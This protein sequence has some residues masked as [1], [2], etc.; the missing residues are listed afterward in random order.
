MLFF[1]TLMVGTFISISAYSWFSMWVGLE[2][3]LLSF[4]PLIW[5]KNNALSSESAIKYFI[6]QS[7][8]SIF[9][10]FSVILN[11]TMSEFFYNISHFFYIIMDSALL[12]KM[13]AAP[14]HFWMP[15]ICEGLTWWNNLILLT[16]QKIA[17]FLLIFFNP[18][19]EMYIIIIIISSMLT[20]GI[21]GWNQVSLR[22]IMVYSSINHMGWMLSFSFLNQSLWIYYFS[23]YTFLSL[24]L[25]IFFNFF[26]INFFQQIFFLL[27]NNKNLKIFF[28]LNFFSL[29]G[30]PPLIGF[31]PKWISISMLLNNNFFI[32]SIIMTLLTL[33]TLYFYLRLSISSLVLTQTN[34]LNYFFLGKKNFFLSLMNFFN[35]LGM[36]LIPLLWNF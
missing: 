10:L 12:T 27:K 23:M 30:L 29:G 24:S 8:A 6:V 34:N 26:K 4:I 19:S 14:F 35:L 32:L 13:G 25:I 15:E 9:I 20:S 33:F 3:N 16:W 36:M 2:I 28:F 21:L 18:L 31:F 5:I 17:P 7:L 22:K 1:N 11:L